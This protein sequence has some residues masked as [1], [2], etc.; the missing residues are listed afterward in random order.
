M[1]TTAWRFR[2]TEGADEAV[3]TLQQL[4]GQEF[5]DVQDVTVLRWPRYATAPMMQEHVTE[6]A[7]KVSIVHKL[8]HPTIESSM[9]ESVKG[10][11]VPGTSIL[12]LLSSDAV[13]DKVAAAFSGSGMELVRSDMSVQQQ[14]QIRSAFRSDGGQ[15]PPPAGGA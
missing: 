1:A 2:G 13:V 10:D 3:L 12:V 6:Q 9:I 7:G 14:D 15:P 5:I 8:R 11:M 4:A